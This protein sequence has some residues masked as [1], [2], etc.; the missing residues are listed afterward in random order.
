MGFVM[1]EGIGVCQTLRVLLHTYSKLGTV[2]FSD[3]HHTHGHCQ[4][5][6]CPSVLMT[7]SISVHLWQVTVG[8]YSKGVMLSCHR[9]GWLE[10]NVPFQHT[11]GYIRDEYPA[12]MPIL[13]NVLTLC[14]SVV[15]LLDNIM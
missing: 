8:H 6:T 14:F 5:Y 13:P 9:V 12:I 2:P 11:Y 3:F 10:F 4:Q 15:K 7:P 1:L